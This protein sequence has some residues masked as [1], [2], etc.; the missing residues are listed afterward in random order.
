MFSEDIDENV[1]LEQIYSEVN[2]EIQINQKQKKQKSSL[3]NSEEENFQTNFTPFI[4]AIDSSLPEI[5]SLRK[6]T[7][8]E[9]Q[10][11]EQDVMKLTLDY[12]HAISQF[13]Q[14]LSGI[15]SNLNSFEEHVGLVG[16]QITSIGKVLQT[17]ERQRE[18]AIK[19]RKILEYFLKFDDPQEKNPES[20]LQKEPIEEA[21]RIITELYKI[22][23]D[24]RIDPKTKEKIEE[25]Q[26]KQKEKIVQYFKEASEKRNFQEMKKQFHIMLLFDDNQTCIQE[27]IRSRKN[28]Y[29]GRERQIQIASLDIDETQKIQTAKR[30]L[31]KFYSKLLTDLRKEKQVIK[32][33]FPFP[34]KVMRILIK[35]IFKRISSYI[36]ELLPKNIQDDLGLYLKLQFTVYQSIL[37]FEKDLD[38]FEIG[39]SDVFQLVQD[40][41]R[42]YKLRY[43]DLELQELERIFIEEKIK[44]IQVNNLISQKIKQTSSS[45]FKFFK[46]LGEKKSHGKKESSKKTPKE[47]PNNFNSQT[48]ANPSKEQIHTP[49]NLALLFFQETSQAIE[50]AKILSPD[51]SVI[52]NIRKIYSA[53]TGHLSEYLEKLINYGL[54]NISTDAS[55]KKINALITH[56]KHVDLMEFPDLDFLDVVKTITQ[57]THLFERFSSIYVI[58]ELMESRNDQTMAIADKS[59]LVNVLES[60]ISSGIHQLMFRVIDRIKAILSLQKKSDFLIKQDKGTPVKATL[61]GKNS[62]IFLSNFG[63]KWKN[64]LLH[65]FEKFKYNTQGG[66]QLLQDVLFYSECVTK[67]G[68]KAVEE[69]FVV[70][71]EMANIFVVSPSN[72]KNI[73]K[74]IRLENDQIMR[75]FHCREDFRSLKF[76]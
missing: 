20:N 42:D 54:S 76:D 9:I 74:E 58:S 1:F 26:K 56:H 27:Y 62:V 70:L 25:E 35:E 37:K 67:F 69:E 19:A 51:F 21:A 48:Q 24:I 60:K 73:K 44:N 43:L 6:N 22:S 15:F 4:S 7:I 47:I 68:I 63:I 31:E 33:V 61:I 50:R 5:S 30:V 11:L 41:F 45:R 8:Q 72:L 75:L 36:T 10:I 66:L 57:I 46:N 17:A 71:R 3:K 64:I 65:H 23:Q 53:M 55:A 14:N 13:K 59:K 34:S 2:Q 40:I 32:Q 49:L 16:K 12:E 18:R 38:E 28:I 29:Q 52:E 39:D